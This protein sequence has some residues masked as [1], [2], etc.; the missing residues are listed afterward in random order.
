M[1]EFLTHFLRDEHRASNFVIWGAAGVIAV[2]LLVALGAM[3]LL[4]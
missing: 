4:K 1:S 2:A 3:L